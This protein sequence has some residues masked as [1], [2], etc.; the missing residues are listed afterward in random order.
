MYCKCGS[1]EKGFLVFQG[2]TK[3]DVTIWTTMFTGLA[4]HGYGNQVLD[5]FF[6]MQQDVM[7]NEVTFV[8][9]L[10]ACT[11]SGL[12]GK[13]LNI[14]YSMKKKF[15]M[16]PQ[17]EHYG[18]LADLLGRSGR[19]A[20]AKDVI[21]K[22]PMKPSCSIWGAML[23]ACR[24]RGNMWNHSD[25]IREVME[26]R[27]VKKTAG[28]SSVVIVGPAHNFIAA[29]SQHPRLLDIFSILQ[30]LN[31]EIKLDDDCSLDMSM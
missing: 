6:L 12:V 28:C 11:H 23:S 7:P 19:L 24:S 29:D 4:F 8:G 15:G 31:S 17:V 25:M 18:C 20:E 16:E 3:K 13:G 30:S 2:V 26:S 10:R 27:G 14:F 1:V 5:L 9:V 22:M 21:E